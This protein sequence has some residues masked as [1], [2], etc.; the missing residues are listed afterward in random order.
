MTFHRPHHQR[1][2][3]VLKAL[4]SS[5]LKSHHCYFGGGTAIALRHGEY[6]ESVGIDF[7][8]SDLSH[9]R[10]LRELVREDNKISSLMNDL[11]KETFK[12]ADVRQDQYGIRTKIG[13]V[14]SMI[15]F[16]IVLE[17][18]IEFCKPSLADEILGVST[19]SDL[20]LASLKFLANSDRGHDTSTHCRDIIDLSMMN[21]TKPQ[22]VSSVEKAKSAYGASVLADFTKVVDMLRTKENLLGKCLIAMQMKL[23]EAVVW[24]KIKKLQK[25][26]NKLNA[27]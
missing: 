14:D 8:V 10:A 12:F 6:R 1:I 22:L 9:Y 18:R 27:G 3:I 20:D 24:Q 16:E 11:G 17:G 13:V 15:K 21:L 23:P 7:M 25:T 26:I 2:A 4:N 5:L 19:L